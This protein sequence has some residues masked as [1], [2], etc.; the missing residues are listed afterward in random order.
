MI[1]TDSLWPFFFAAACTAAIAWMR[2]ALLLDPPP[3]TEV[4]RGKGISRL[5]GK[6][7]EE[8]RPE[9]WV[10]LRRHWPATQEHWTAAHLNINITSICFRGLGGVDK[11]P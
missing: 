1:R 4:T 5:F 7:V 11:D 3:A 2:C 6:N 10:E 8:E 9:L